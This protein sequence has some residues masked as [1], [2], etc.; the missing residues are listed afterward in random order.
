MRASMPCM[1]I[2]KKQNELIEVGRLKSGRKE[3][4]RKREK[5]EK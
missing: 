3:G 4:K 5:E 2:F 1:S